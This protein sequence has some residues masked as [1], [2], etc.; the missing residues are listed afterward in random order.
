MMCELKA[1][2]E[3]QR[4]LH[5]RSAVQDDS[6]E[7]A[8]DDDYTR[9]T[10]IEHLCCFVCEEELDTCIPD[11]SQVYLQCYHADCVMQCHP[12]C[13]ADHFI[14]SVDI[15]TSDNEGSDLSHQ[16][17]SKT[18][19]PDRGTCPDC[20]NALLWPLLVQQA[21]ARHTD[22]T[23]RRNKRRKRYAE[24]VETIENGREVCPS[25]AAEQQDEGSS[26]SLWDS[27][28]AY[29]DE[30]WFDEYGARGDDEDSEDTP[31]DVEEPSDSNTASLAL[32]NSSV[33]AAT[34]DFNH[35]DAVFIDLTL[36]ED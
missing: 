33:N 18:L 8:G 15:L 3:F 32:G 20:Q 11:S 4:V 17:D 1:L 24:A 31:M 22:S 34:S 30:N 27:R 12:L 28:I 36:D 10:D 9:Y 23:S 26:S 35:P 7:E 14:S 2:V 16:Q 6:R 21:T 25:R 13:L 29:S 19:R 5:R